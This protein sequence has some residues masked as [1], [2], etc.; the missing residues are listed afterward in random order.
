M[1]NAGRRIGQILMG[2][3]GV[4]AQPHRFGGVEFRVGRQELGHTH[5]DACV[6]VVLPR[7]LRDELVI[8]GAAEP[9]PVIPDSGWVTVTLNSPE[10]VGNA[11]VLLRRSYELALAQ[12]ARAEQAAGLARVSGLEYDVTPDFF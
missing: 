10:D 7:G 6:D 3:D 1:T 5:G 2:W 12:R 8:G 9:H 4:T 11:L